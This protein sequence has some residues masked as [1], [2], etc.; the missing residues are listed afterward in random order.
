MTT[1]K[2][3]NPL[4][5][6]LREMWVPQLLM[7]IVALVLGVFVVAWPGVSILAASVLLGLYLVASGIA[8]VIL[9]F[10][11]D[12]S[13][14]YRVL[15]FITGALSLILGVLAFRHFGQGYA[16]LLLALWIGI[17]FIFQGVAAATIAIS[18]RDLPGRGW[19]IFFGVTSVI[20]GL[21]MLVW[22][23][24]SIVVLAYVTGIMLVVIGITQIFSSFGTRHDL[25]TAEKRVSRV[26]HTNR[27]A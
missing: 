17:G 12:V 15:L 3:P 9:A 7:G 25:R 20:A 26:I 4:R 14:G 19:H 1:T 18:S 22:P 13:G 16:V 5:E 21:V 2:T 6:M 8:Q 27:A 23:F 11:L 24:D 10:G